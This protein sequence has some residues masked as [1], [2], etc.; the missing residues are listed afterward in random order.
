M[1]KFEPDE[2]LVLEVRKHIF[3]F[4]VHTVAHMFFAV[5]P[6]VGFVIVNIVLDVNISAKI[7]WLLSTGYSLWLLVIWVIYFIQWT[8]YYLDVW[9]ITDK[10]IIAIDQKGL[11]RR[12][13]IDLRYEKVQDATI[14]IRGIISTLLTFGDI[15]IQT[16]GIHRDIILKNAK[17]PGKAKEIILSRHSNV[18]EK[19]GH[20]EP[21]TE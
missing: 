1:I 12:E 14:E 19:D 20:M 13:V 5:V 3:V 11:F 15:Q 17:N 16:A 18:F 10:R 21:I 7:F 6:I 4:I 2:Y 8:D 9:Y